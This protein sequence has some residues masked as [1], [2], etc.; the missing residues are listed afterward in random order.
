VDGKAG[1]TSKLWS[2]IEFYLNDGS[3]VIVKS[4]K[5]LSRE[6]IKDR[7]ENAH[8]NGLWVGMTFYPSYSI[9]KAE[10]E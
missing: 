9:K 6:E 2:Q 4:E 8:R 3:R 10:I 1:E 7:V 5:A